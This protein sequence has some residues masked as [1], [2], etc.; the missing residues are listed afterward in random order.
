MTSKKKDNLLDLSSVNRK[1]VISNYSEKYPGLF[2]KEKSRIF[3]FGYKIIDS[4]EHIGSTSV[5]GLLGKPTID[6]IVRLIDGEAPNS[7][8]SLFEKNNYHFI[9]ELIDYRPERRIF[10]M[11]TPEKHTHHIHVVGYSSIDWNSMI[12]FRN[13]LR[14]NQ[15]AREEYA[16]LKKELA[17]KHRSDIGKYV[18]GKDEFYSKIIS[19][20]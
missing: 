1:I 20:L 4:I 6:I 10:W 12:G 7:S 3:S 5:P 15:R 14:N 8:I 2:Q 18:M 16:R 11:G 13:S 19:T 17:M 9:P